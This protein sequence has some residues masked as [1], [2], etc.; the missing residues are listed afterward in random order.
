MALTPAQ[1]IQLGLDDPAPGTVFAPGSQAPH[2]LDG[3]FL[4]GAANR[5]TLSGVQ[6]I[7]NPRLQ[8]SPSEK[9]TPAKIRSLVN[10]LLAL[11][12]DTANQAL[13]ALFIANPKVGLETFIELSK[14]AL[15]QLKAIA[16]QVDDRSENP[17]HLSFDQLQRALAADG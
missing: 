17:R 1:R 9:V 8:L 3:E 16:V 5:T 2:P 14:F 11:N 10:E 13:Q 7:P 4:G 15:P 12:I 6:S